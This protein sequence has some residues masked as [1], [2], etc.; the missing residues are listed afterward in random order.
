MV[1]KEKE[2]TQPQC[3]VI[4]QHAIS[5]RA[6]SDSWEDLWAFSLLR[7]MLCLP[8]KC[9]GD[10]MVRPVEGLGWLTWLCFF[11]TRWLVCSIPWWQQTLVD[12]LWHTCGFCV[13][14]VVF[15]DKL[16]GNLKCFRKSSRKSFEVLD[17]GDGAYRALLL[18]LKGFFAERV[19]LSVKTW[20]SSFFFL[21]GFCHIGVQ[22]YYTM[23]NALCIF[24]CSN[25][26]LGF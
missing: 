11:M 23:Q 17:W 16:K 26:N 1:W 15:T 18:L 8:V 12:E 20:I 9:I 6:F 2:N 10:W 14:D 5:W 22:S 21:A 13:L 24:N 7:Y 3:W 19:S 25:I 4:I